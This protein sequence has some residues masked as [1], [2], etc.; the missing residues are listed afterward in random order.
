MEPLQE[1]LNTS[2]FFLSQHDYLSTTSLPFSNDRSNFTQSFETHRIEKSRDGAAKYAHRIRLRRVVGI[3]M[4]DRKRSCGKERDYR[5]AAGLF[6]S[7]FEACKRLSSEDRQSLLRK[8]EKQWSRHK[9]PAEPKQYKTVEI[10]G[11]EIKQSP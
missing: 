10:I 11:I 3:K 8:I 2:A 4:D 6:E 7:A 5:I 1:H 9:P